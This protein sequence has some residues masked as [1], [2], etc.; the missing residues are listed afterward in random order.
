MNEFNGDIQTH[1]RLEWPN[2]TN[3]VKWRPADQTRDTDPINTGR[4]LLSSR[5]FSRLTTVEGGR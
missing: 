5:C 3:G 4:S 2:G 1:K